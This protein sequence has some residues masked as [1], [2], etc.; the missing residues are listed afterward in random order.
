MPLN[1]EINWAEGMFLRP[2]HLQAASRH[3]MSYLNHEVGNIRPFGWGI[4]ALSIS[5]AELENFAFSIRTCQIRMRDGTWLCVPENADIEPRDFK[6]VLD[7]SDGPVDVFVG[8]PRFRERDANTLGLGESP[9]DYDRRYRVRLTELAD[10]NTGSNLQQIEARRLAGRLFF[11]DEDTQGYDTLRVA[12]V[13][14]SG[15]AQNVPVVSSSFFPPVL[16][17]EA[18]PALHNVCRDIYHKLAARNR[19]LASQIA[20]RDVSFGSQTAGGAEAMLKLQVTNGF[21]V[22]LRQLINTPR[23]HPYNV[24]LE[25]CRMAGELAV[26][27]ETREAPD[28]P[29]Y[30]HDQ[31]GIC[32]FEL[33]EQLERLLDSIIPTAYVRRPFEMVQNQLQCSLDE[34]WLSRDMDIYLGIEADYEEELVVEKVKAVKLAASEDIARINQRRLPGLRLQPVRRVPAGLPDRAG[35]HYFRISREGELWEGVQ[36]DKSVAI[37][38]PTDP[39]MDLYIYVV[40]KR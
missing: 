2:H 24:Y 36:R 37:S 19:S 23:V 25:L 39:A 35:S 20:A 32:F 9:G 3:L 27:D 26:F 11:G 17:V 6:E 8:I 30:D 29:V 10:E 13:E 5:E 40:L 16:A 18:W 14:R 28:L 1:P 7:T 4:N 31:L 33:S 22:V 38:G 34:E 15:G 21:V 12:R